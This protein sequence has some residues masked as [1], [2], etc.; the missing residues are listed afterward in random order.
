MVLVTQVHDPILEFGLVRSQVTGT[1]PELYKTSFRLI[2]SPIPIPS[3][4]M[5]DSGQAY[6]IINK[7][8]GTALDLSGDDQRSIIGFASH[9]S[10]NQKV[11]YSH[12]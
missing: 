9:R 12:S 11:R 3:I 1:P 5:P 4:T 6:F 10:D 8:S 7:K 2:S